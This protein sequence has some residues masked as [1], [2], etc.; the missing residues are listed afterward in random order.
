MWRA[1]C[2]FYSA[3]YFN[4]GNTGDVHSPNCFSW[5]GN[6]EW[7]DTLLTRIC[8]WNRN[9]SQSGSL[10]KIWENSSRSVRVI[11]VSEKNI[12]QAFYAI[13]DFEGTG[14]LRKIFSNHFVLLFLPREIFSE[15]L[16]RYLPER[17]Y[18][19]SVG[20]II[21]SK[22]NISR[23]SVLLLFRRKISSECANYYFFKIIRSIV[24]SAA[25]K[26]SPKLSR[27]N[28]FANSRLQY[29]ISRCTLKLGSFRKRPS[30]SRKN[31]AP[32]DRLEELIVLNSSSYFIE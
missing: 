15:S 3:G 31:S 4:T 5:K 22:R 14:S 16:Y 30:S 24:A 18:C 26:G 28:R 27:R 21:Y 17:T 8:A 7:K 9:G 19:P 32:S 20:I 1:L 10:S 23:A 2:I 29:T 13:T 11:T 6:I 12:F 25:R